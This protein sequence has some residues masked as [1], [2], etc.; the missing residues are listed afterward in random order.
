M[1]QHNRA[2]RAILTGLLISTI[3]VSLSWGLTEITNRNAEAQ[4]R[5]TQE[6]TVPETIKEVTEVIIELP[7][8]ETEAEP[9]DRW[10]SY[11]G[12]LLARIAMAEAESEDT[13]CKA[14]VILTVLNRV[15]S[16]SF[17]D[18]IEEVIFQKGQFSPISNGRWDRVEPDK[19]CWAALDLVESGWNES[20]GALYF[21]ASKDHDTWH[22]RNLVKLFEHGV[23]TFYTEDDAV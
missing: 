16:D 8:V 23:T 10:T 14:L 12:Y 17:P 5:K 13:E 20:Q 21:E 1:R 18:S 22:S 2:F 19:D 6:Q 4:K 15:G 3:A 7:K 9:E 11:E